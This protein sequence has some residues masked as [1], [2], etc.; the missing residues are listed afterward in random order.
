MLTVQTIVAKN[1][2]ATKRKWFAS[3][4]AGP[5]GHILCAKKKMVT[6]VGHTLPVDTG[7]T[8]MPSQIKTCIH[9]TER[10]KIWQTPTFQ[11]K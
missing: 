4:T 1:A 2:K 9:R 8:E 6:L 5:F 7:K 10:K 11:K 3:E